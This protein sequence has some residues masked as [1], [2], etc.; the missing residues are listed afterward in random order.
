VTQ[1]SSIARGGAAGDSNATD[2]LFPDKPFGV[3]VQGKL[4]FGSQASNPESPGFNLDSRAITVDSDYRFTDKLVAGAAIEYNYVH[5]SF[6]NGGGSMQTNSIIGALY[7]SYYLPQDFYVDGL[8]TFGNN[9]YALTRTF[10]YPDFASSATSS[11][12]AFQYAF[13][14]TAGKDIAWQQ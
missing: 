11:P 9:N 2:D 6:N 14:V 1:K 3:F 13:A 12:D 5:T 8:A 7:S 10:Q 4:D